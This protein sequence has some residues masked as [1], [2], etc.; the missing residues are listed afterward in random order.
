MKNPIRIIPIKGIIIIMFVFIMLTMILGIGALVFGRWL[1]TAEETTGQ[2]A[3]TISDSIYDQV[4]SL[5]H[6]PEHI[7]EVNLKILENGILDL[8]DEVL[9]EK[10]F[11]GVLQSQED[12]IYSFSFGTVNG[13]YYGARRNKNNTIEI[14]RN[15]AETGGNSWY[16]AVNEDLTAGELVVQAGL[17][18]PRTRVWFQAA[19]D[20]EAPI[21]S[22]IY[23]HFIMD[24]LTV[25]AA[26]PVYSSTGELQ[27]VLGTHMLLSGIG[28]VLEDAT[29]ERVVKAEISRQK[30]IA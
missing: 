20:T 11:V 4:S 6:V 24:D 10:F 2:I 3:T 26:R 7:N 15:N 5:I 18:D 13:E 16:Y 17:F 1:T 21:F 22:P 9:R 8:S 30:T 29:R 19:V 12:E 23:K 28:A 25:S 14:M 27:G